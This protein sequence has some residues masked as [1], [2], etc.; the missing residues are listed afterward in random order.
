MSQLVVIMLEYLT[1][2]CNIW[3]LNNYDEDLIAISV[4]ALLSQG[5]NIDA[6]DVQKWLKNNDWDAQAAA[7]FKLI[8]SL[9]A[10]GKKI[11]INDIMSAPTEKA[12]L[13]LFQDEVKREQ[14]A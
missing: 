6:D 2:R 9:L 10:S 13:K 1:R 4:N 3:Q 12:M 5:E 14:S 8:V 11:Q 7:K